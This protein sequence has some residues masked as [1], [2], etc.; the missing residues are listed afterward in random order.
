[1]GEL[2]STRRVF[3][4]EML[5]ALL[6]AVSLAAPV[7]KY[8]YFPRQGDT[9]S[10][11]FYALYPQSSQTTSPSNLVMWLQGGP[12]GSSLF[13]DFL[14]NGPED[15]YGRA[16][17]TSWTNYASMLYVDNPIGTGFSYTTDNGYSTT[18]EGVAAG[19]VDFLAQFFNAYPDLQ[20]VPF[21]IFTESYGGKMTAFTGVALHE[22]IEAGKVKSNFQGVALGDGWLDGADCMASYAPFLLAMSLI[23]EEQAKVVTQY[24]TEA[25]A[26]LEANNGTQAT[27]LWGEQQQYISE[28]CDGCNW[29]NSINS[30]DTDA[31]EAQLNKNCHS[32]GSFYEY[33]KSVVP[34][35]V[36]YGSQAGNVFS[37][38]SDAFLRSGV[39]QV[40]KMLQAGLKVNVYSGQLDIIVDALCT[41]RWINNMSW[42]GLAKFQQQPEHNIIIDGIPQGFYRSFENFA[43]FKIFR[44][45][46]MVPHDNPEAAYQ[47]LQ[48]ILGGQVVK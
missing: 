46:H 7:F 28:S 39:E 24:A 25:A 14:E 48:M 35:S 27:N 12:G 34:S 5:I 17:A 6:F 30:T 15:V 20:S 29:Y 13:G 1:M 41:E 44:A 31:A 42:P 2:K 22:A 4:L 33:V 19:L 32:G 9:N 10:Q 47:M 26:A 11:Y 16:R 37:E 3:F 8:G 40:V 36:N 45:G 18:D 21:W 38:M 23:D 43:F